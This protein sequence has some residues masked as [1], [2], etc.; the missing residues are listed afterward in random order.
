[1]RVLPV[2]VLPCVARQLARAASLYEL[3]DTLAAM[4]LTCRAWARA[5]DDNMGNEDALDVLHAGIDMVCGMITRPYCTIV[6]RRQ[7][8]LFGRPKQMACN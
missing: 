1:M 6:R 7:G 5:V 3:R 2:D 4:R 8:L